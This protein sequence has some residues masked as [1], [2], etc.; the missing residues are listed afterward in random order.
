MRYSQE[1]FGFYFFQ[2]R[3]LP[4]GAGTVGIASRLQGAAVVS[5]VSTVPATGAH[6]QPWTVNWGGTEEGRLM[7]AEKGLLAAASGRQRLHVG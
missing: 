6:R 1:H 7:T 2:D 4:R 5:A 3:Q